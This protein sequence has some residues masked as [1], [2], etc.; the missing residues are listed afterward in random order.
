VRVYDEATL[1]EGRVVDGQRRREVHLRSWLLEYRW[2]KRCSITVKVVWLGTKWQPEPLEAIQAS[3][4]AGEQ[5]TRHQNVMTASR[6]R[7]YP[8]TVG[9]CH[10]RHW[11]KLCDPEICIIDLVAACYSS[12]GHMP[13]HTTDWSNDYCWMYS[14]SVVCFW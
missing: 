5:N 1:K 13:D 6:L 2:V 3:P 7:A 8:Q 10:E 4:I 11:Y 9:C 12:P 14:K